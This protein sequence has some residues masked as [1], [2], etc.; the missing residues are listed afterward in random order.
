M[1][2]VSNDYKS[3][4]ESCESCQTECQSDGTEDSS[5]SNTDLMIPCMR[6]QLN[7]LPKS[8]IWQK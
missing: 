5:D 2:N 8:Q 3:A 1:E 4:S 6:L 7:Q